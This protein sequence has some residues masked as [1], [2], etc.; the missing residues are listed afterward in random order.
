MRTAPRKQLVSVCALILA[1]TVLPSASAA[2][3]G[4]AARG[5]KAGTAAKRP[6]A[7]P[8]PPPEPVYDVSDD[9]RDPFFPPGSAKRA[10]AE[11]LARLRTASVLA[12]IEPFVKVQGIVATSAGESLAL[13]NGK[14]QKKG[15]RLNLK[16][17]DT[18]VEI[19]VLDI[20]AEPPKVTF[21]WKKQEFSKM[22]GSNKNN[23]KGEGK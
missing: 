21:Q 7:V 20:M 2:Q 10:D 3:T 17:G 13:V 4:E 15:S 22:P 5:K 23:Q 16:F 19:V 9:A 6:A 8:Q 14:L 12:Q 18:S 1:T 11:A